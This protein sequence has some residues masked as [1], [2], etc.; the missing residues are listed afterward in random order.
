VF[1]GS[2]GTLGS[3]LAPEINALRLYYSES[4]PYVIYG[5][6]GFFGAAFAILIRK[7]A[8]K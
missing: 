4:L 7:N 3:I 5:L 2:A 8:Q 6:V 1:L